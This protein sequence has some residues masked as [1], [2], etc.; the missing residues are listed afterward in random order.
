MYC[1]CCNKRMFDLKEED[2]D[3]NEFRIKCIVEKIEVGYGSKFDGDILRICICEKCLESKI[4]SGTV[5]YLGN[6]LGFDPE[7]SQE[8]IAKSKN[9]YKRRKNLDNLI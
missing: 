8:E 2:W 9:I 6:Y 4:K 7:I 5:L 3:T 1:L